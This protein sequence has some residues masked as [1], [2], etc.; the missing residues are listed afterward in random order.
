MK[1]SLTVKEAAELLGLSKDTI[2][3]MARENQLPHVRAGSRILFHRPRLEAW[4][5]GE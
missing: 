3:R 1:I 4:L 5:A 2:Y